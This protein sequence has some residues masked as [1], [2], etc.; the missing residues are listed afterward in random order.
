MLIQL[1][2]AFIA[3]DECLNAESATHWCLFY[4]EELFLYMDIKHSSIVAQKRLQRGNCLWEQ[5]I[6]IIPSI[7]TLAVK[8]ITFTING[9]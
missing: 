7:V 5:A 8:P 2:L 3:R 6:T 4:T 1:P 9:R